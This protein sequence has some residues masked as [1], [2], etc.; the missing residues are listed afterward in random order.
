MALHIPQSI[1]HLAQF[2]FVRPETFGPS[3]VY[4]HSY[5]KT[6]IAGYSYTTVK[7]FWTN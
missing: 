5:M 1:F 6:E 7:F 3:Y 4:M 2:L